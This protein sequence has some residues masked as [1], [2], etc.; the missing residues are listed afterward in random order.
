MGAYK[1]A[2]GDGGLQFGKEDNGSGMSADEK[3]Y[4]RCAIPTDG[5]VVAALTASSDPMFH[6]PGAL[7][8]WANRNYGGGT[9]ASTSPAEEMRAKLAA[10]ALAAFRWTPTGETER[11]GAVKSKYDLWRVASD[12]T[13][14]LFQ[15]ML[16]AVTADN[17]FTDES[18]G[19]NDGKGC[20][21]VAASFNGVSVKNVMTPLNDASI[22]AGA[23]FNGVL[24]VTGAQLTV[25]TAQTILDITTNAAPHT[26]D[27]KAKL[28]ELCN[29]KCVALPGYAYYTAVQCRTPGNCCMGT[30][31]LLDFG[32]VTADT[33]KVTAAAQSCSFVS[34]PHVVA[35]AA[36]AADAGGTTFADAPRNC[37]K[38]ATGASAAW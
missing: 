16:S 24:D 1:S 23:V 32:S 18:T 36:A 17:G 5:S 4:Y 34:G 7:T 37:Q 19:G 21:D 14:V 27:R 35:A 25:V 2:A 29:A 11:V 3:A 15:A 10:A 33:T 20:E 13:V 12:A 9:P 31:V 28:I 26:A 22:L 38:R 6:P 30:Q 8:A